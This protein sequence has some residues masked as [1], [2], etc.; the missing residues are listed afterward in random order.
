MSLAES[1]A[2]FKEEKRLEELGQN[3]LVSN[4]PF[5]VLDT[6]VQTE[7]PSFGEKIKEGFCKKFANK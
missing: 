3:A 6:N 4:N 1:V 5:E 2:E 7:K